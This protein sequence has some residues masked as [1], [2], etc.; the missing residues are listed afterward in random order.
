MEFVVPG[1]ILLVG[2]LDR[3]PAGQRPAICRLPDRRGSGDEQGLVA[4]RTELVRSSLVVIFLIFFL[5]VRPVRL[6]T[7]FGR[8]L[9]KAIGVIHTPGADVMT[10]R[11]TAVTLRLSPWP[12]PADIRM[13]NSTEVASPP[14]FAGSPPTP[15]SSRLQGR[16][17]ERFAVRS[18]A[19]T[20]QSRL[21]SCR[22]RSRRRSATSD[23]DGRR[24]SRDVEPV[25]PMETCHPPT[26]PRRS[27]CHPRRR[28]RSEPPRRSKP[29]RHRPSQRPAE[30][31][32]AEPQA[33]PEEDRAE[34]G[35]VH[36][37]GAE[38]P[39]GLDPRRPAAPGGDRRA[40]RVLSARSS[41]RPKM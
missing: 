37:Q 23:A 20:F 35:L 34:D 8:S 11:P 1:L 40:G 12:R 2:R 4:T 39:R 10:N 19:G 26:S 15:R 21:R 9:F 41:C 22:K 33:E 6:S 27:R 13:P 25:P 30:A 5:A 14:N 18:R 16:V 36:P 17:Q 7:S 31:T 32:A 29:S 28:G 24:G 3:L 38:Q